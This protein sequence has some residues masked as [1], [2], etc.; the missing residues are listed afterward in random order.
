M[1]ATAKGRMPVSLDAILRRASKIAETTFDKRGEITPFWLLET[2]TGKQEMAV[3]PYIVPPDVPAHG[4][5][6]K[7]AE[8]MREF[9]REH[10]V[11]RY[12]HAAEAWSVDDETYQGPIA[13]H[14]NRKEVVILTADDGNEH[15]SAFCD[16]IR[17]PHGKPY[18]GKLSEIARTKRPQGRLTN[19][20]NDVRPSSELPDDEGTVFVTDVPSAPFQIVGRRG[21]TGELFAGHILTTPPLLPGET[22]SQFI[23][24]REVETGMKP[25]AIEIVTGPEAERLLAGVM[26]KMPLQ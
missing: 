26:R 1:S 19:L 14:P 25:P 24:R 20:I 18:L 16:I 22:T 7:I 3:S 12:A 2:S 15:L 11:V 6:L 8:G 5:K 23:A 17:P 4:A 9:F 13:E 10:D 21:P